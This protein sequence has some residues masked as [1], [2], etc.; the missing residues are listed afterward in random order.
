[1]KIRTRLCALATLTLLAGAMPAFAQDVP[2]DA[3]KALWCSTAFGLV[4]PQAKAQGQADAADKF[5]KY[6]K[7]LAGTGSDALKKAGFTDDQ[8]KTASASYTDKVT[9]EL[10]GASAP[11]FSIYD[12]T[13]LVDPAAAAAMQAAPADNSAAP[14]G[15]TTPAPDAAAPAAPAAPASN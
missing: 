9:K 2:A 3:N 4:A 10:Q 6:S 8:V 12:C 14:A 1:M 15:G 7:T 13:M 5:D 11:E